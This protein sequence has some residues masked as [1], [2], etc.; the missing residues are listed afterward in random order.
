MKQTFYNLSPIFYAISPMMANGLDIDQRLDFI[1]CHISIKE[2]GSTRF[3]GCK[4]GVDIG[5]GVQSKEHC[6][7]LQR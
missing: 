4:Y 3:Y 5:H 6:P 1:L 7:A 2:T